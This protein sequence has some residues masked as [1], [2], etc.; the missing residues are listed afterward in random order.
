MSTEAEEREIVDRMSIRMRRKLRRN[1][2]KTHWD[3]L[4]I[5][6]L[7]NWLKGEVKE[8][9]EALEKGE[10]PEAIAYECADIGNFAAM[11][12]AKTLPKTP[13]FEEKGQW[14]FYDEQ[15]IE[16]YGP[17]E[18]KQEAERG[19]AV[20]A[21]C[22]VEE[23]PVTSFGKIPSHL[24]R[25]L[26]NFW[27]VQVDLD[28]VLYPSVEHAYQAAKTLDPVER[29]KL[30]EA[31]SPGSAKRLGRSLTIRPDWDDATRLKVMRPLLA[32]KFLTEPLRTWLMLT[33]RVEIAEGNTWGDTFW[34]RIP[35]GTGS[36]H[37]GKMLME[38]RTDLQSDVR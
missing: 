4:S 37:L 18:S 20:Y 11:I 10:H 30:R 28:G 2:H 16:R 23:K 22:I 26:S 32:Q 3:Q 12:M 9:E 21:E 27:P 14:F 25:F 5:P 38:I 15:W 7:L 13:V 34:G 36:N 31:V 8:L 33:G 6:D 19:A 35:N 17:F 29:E 1:S 24:F